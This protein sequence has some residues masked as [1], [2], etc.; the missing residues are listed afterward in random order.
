MEKSALLLRPLLVKLVQ[1]MVD[2]FGLPSSRILSFFILQ[3]NGGL[4]SSEVNMGVG[5]SFYQGILLLL[6]QTGTISETDNWLILHEVAHQWLGVGIYAGEADLE[7]FFEGMASWCAMT[8]SRDLAYMTEETLHQ[9]LILEGDRYCTAAKTVI[10][11]ESGEIDPCHFKQ[12]KIRGGLLLAFGL[13]LFFIRQGDGNLTDF[14]RYLY[15]K[16]K[17][18]AI[19]KDDIIEAI[20]KK[21]GEGIP[22]FV[23]DFLEQKRLLP[24]QEWF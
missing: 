2:F 19:Y 3:R 7:W 12:Y 10:G 20:N 16:C 15:K 14:L 5:L 13:D 9:L 17:G 24:F 22:A 4:L 8:L 18:E 23:H 21:S 6:N 11:R 1:S